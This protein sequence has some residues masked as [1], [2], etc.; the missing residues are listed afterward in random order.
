MQK[1]FSFPSRKQN[2][3]Q[4]GP[5][6]QSHRFA[7]LAL[8]DLE[9]FSHTT[10]AHKTLPRGAVLLSC[11]IPD[12]QSLTLTILVLHTGANCEKLRIKVIWQLVSFCIPF[13]KYATKLSKE[14][15]A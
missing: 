12:T 2:S 3:S 11:L 5:H 8:K 4:G 6:S 14:T 15:N 10:L 13:R 1:A 9:E 7:A